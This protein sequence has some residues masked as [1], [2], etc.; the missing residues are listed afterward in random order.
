MFAK[1]LKTIF[2][3]FVHTK[4]SRGKPMRRTCVPA[5]KVLKMEY[6][7][8]T[9]TSKQKKNDCKRKQLLKE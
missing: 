9:I 1:Q 6:Q 7:T 4:S 3:G 2:A 8:K 5:R